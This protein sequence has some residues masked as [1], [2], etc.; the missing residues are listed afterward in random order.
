MTDEKR[1]EKKIFVDHRANT[2]VNRIIIS[3]SSFFLFLAE[4]FF[5]IRVC[6]RAKKERQK[7][8]LFP[9]NE[10]ATYGQSHQ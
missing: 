5:H 9:I 6:I 3:S 7:F 4:N 2:I 10:T 8:M 1:K